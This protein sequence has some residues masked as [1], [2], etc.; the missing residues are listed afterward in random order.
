MNVSM[1]SITRCGAA[2]LV[3]ALATTASLAMFTGPVFA[4]DGAASVFTFITT[5]EGQHA[6]KVSYSDLDLN[7]QAGVAALL[8]RMQH[9]AHL[10]CD[11]G[12][13][14]SFDD[15]AASRQCEQQAVDRGVEHVGNARLAALRRGS[16]A[17]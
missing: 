16:S 4:H 9:A 15:W 2:A 17:G 8:R 13:P 10:V 6:V 11:A 14:H 12:A 7:S 1:S 5:S 3:A